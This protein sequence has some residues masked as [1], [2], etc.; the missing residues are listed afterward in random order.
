[1]KKIF[2][3]LGV[4][5]YI[6]CFSQNL[7]INFEGDVLTSDFINF[8]GGTATVSTNPSFSGI[9]TSDGV[10]RIVRNGGAIWGGSKITLSNALDFSVLTKITMKV[11]TTAPVGTVV[12]FKIE[13]TDDAADRDAVT[14]VSGQW[15]VLEWVFLL[16][17]NNLNEV[18]FMFDFGNVGDGSTNS[19]FYFDDVEQVLGPAPPNMLTLPINFE[20]GSVVDSDF[21]NFSGAGARVI[22]NP[23]VDGLNGSNTVCEIIRNGGD[24]WAGC[25]MFLANNLDFSSE[26]NISM[27]FFT[28]A[29]IGTRLK[30]ELENANGVRGLD[31]V[32]TTTGE[33]ETATWNFYG[34]DNDYNRINF[35]FDFGNVGN[36]SSNS[37]F[38]FDDLQQFAGPAIPAAQKASLPIDFETNVVDSDFTN[39]F[40]GFF[41]VIPNPET[42]SDNPSSTVG[43]F[44]RS[45][46]NGAPW[47]Q[48]KLGLTEF[49]DFPTLNAVS[50]KVF[51]NA[52][53]GTILKLKVEGLVSGA[54]NEK[55]VETTVS[56][57]WETYTWDFASGDP[58]IY[59]GLVFMF[60]YATPNNASASATYLIDDIQLVNTS[61][62]VGLGKLLTSDEFKIYPNPANESVTI[63]ANNELIQSVI[64]FDMFGNQVKNVQKDNKVVNINVSNLSK[65][66]YV[67]EISTLNQI[68]NKKVIVD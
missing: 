14:T 50:M 44:I 16:P 20:S 45:G 58:A 17:P 26:W 61:T 38:L 19:T 37:T 51:S 21:F 11:Y 1:M 65:G 59:D 54:A 24:F 68:I 10:G 27:K 66:I 48:S 33:W 12:K 31:Y 4:F 13:N 52:P 2:F 41:S 28:T 23:Q 42:N 43:Q 32:T 5:S 36:G 39:V 18:V 9:N 15:E 67:V 62:G 30:L 8:D 57:A 64:L 29:P 34:W 46:G 7:P 6:L 3:S 53:V 47:A 22:S 56:G 40:G 49:M 63:S 55:N 60:G 25:K 35:L